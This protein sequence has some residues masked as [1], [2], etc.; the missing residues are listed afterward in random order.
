MLVKVTFYHQLSHQQKHTYSEDYFEIYINQNVV[1]SYIV[2]KFS[3]QFIQQNNKF[4]NI[5]M[6]CN[7]IPLER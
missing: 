3:H 7:R 6:L 4:E 5:Q 2:S 1:P